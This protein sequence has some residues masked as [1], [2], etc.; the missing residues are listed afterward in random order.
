MVDPTPKP[1]VVSTTG[2]LARRSGNVGVPSS[3]ITVDE[4]KNV[5]EALLHPPS[6]VNWVTAGTSI[7]GAIYVAAK[8][9]KDAPNGKLEGAGLYIFVISILVV[10]GVF[11]TTWKQ[12]FQKYP[13]HDKALRDVRELIA[14]QD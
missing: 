7:L 11:A 9:L 10:G 13:H 12:R 3:K 14:S 4:L 2:N 8:A 5:E 6:K 1:N